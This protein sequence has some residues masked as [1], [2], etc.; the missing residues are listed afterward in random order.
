WNRLL[1]R[2]EEAE[3]EG[4]IARLP[5]GTLRNQ[6]PDWLGGGQVE[7]VVASVALC[8]GIPHA[9]DKLLYK[10]YSNRPWAGLFQAQRNFRAYLKPMFDSAPD[11]LTVFDPV[12]DRVRTLW[13]EGVHD[14]P[15]LAER[16]GVSAM[17]VR[18]RLDDVG[19]LSI[20]PRGRSDRRHPLGHMPE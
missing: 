10:H 13:S 8:H 3:G 9:G 7:A 11:V 14:I 16:A 4:K 5:F 19:L 6:L 15:T 18:R 12:A 1:D 2:I 20:I 17:T